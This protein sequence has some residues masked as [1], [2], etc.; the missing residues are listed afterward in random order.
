VPKKTTVYID[1]F[2][3]YFGIREA[4]WKDLLWLDMIAFSK[5]F[6]TESQTLVC[7]KYFTSRI[8]NDP[9]K[10][11]RQNTY[12]DALDTLRKSG[13]E[14]FYGDY[15]DEPWFCDRCQFPNIDHHEKQTDVNI[16]V[17]MMAD[18]QND[19]FQDA[20]LISADSDQVPTIREIRE[21]WPDRRVL[22]IFPPNR[23]SDELIGVAHSH[24]HIN[25]RSF[26]DSVQLP[27][28]VIGLTGFPLTRPATWVSE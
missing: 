15:L 1:G 6:L 9:P 20:I 26:L 8:K 25:A 4:R 28:E 7:T 12:L 23:H 19:K 13:L 18:A 2:N 24:L 17:Q 16:A 14:I 11:K 3:L 22:V 5:Q 10:Q 21:T 27:D